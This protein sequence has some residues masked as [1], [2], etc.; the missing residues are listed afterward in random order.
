ML[1]VLKF[2]FL[3]FLQTEKSLVSSWLKPRR[4]ASSFLFGSAFAFGWTPC[5]G[6]VLGSIL[7]LASASATAATGALLLAVF[8]LGLATP[9]LLIAAGIGSVGI[10]L[11]KASPYLNVIGGLFLLFLGILLV[12]DKFGFWLAYAYRLFNFIDYDRLLDYL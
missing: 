1:G 2:R 10:W 6:P 3:N 11:A 4:P 5:V 7:L 12:T 8:S 9:F